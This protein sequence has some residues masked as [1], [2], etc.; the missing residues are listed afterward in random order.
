[1]KGFFIVGDTHDALPFRD[2]KRILT[3][4]RAAEHSPG[5]AKPTALA[6]RYSE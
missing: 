3:A 4:N 6:G 2:R 5:S 1:V